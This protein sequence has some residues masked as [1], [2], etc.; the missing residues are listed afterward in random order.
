MLSKMSAMLESVGGLPARF[1]EPL[2]EKEVLLPERWS[3]CEVKNTRGWAMPSAELQDC[4]RDSCRA[5]VRR[6]KKG[7]SGA[8]A[9]V[10][11]VSTVSTA[12]TKVLALRLS[13]PRDGVLVGDGEEEAVTELEAEGEEVEDARR[14]GED[15]ELPEGD[16]LVHTVGV[17]EKID[18][19][20][21]MGQGLDE[22]L[23]VGLCAGLPL[24]VTVTVVEPL[25]LPEPEAQAE[26]VAEGLDEML[27]L[28]LLLCVAEEQ[29][30]ED[31]E[32]E[33]VGEGVE[34]AQW[35]PDTE[36]LLLSEAVPEGVVVTV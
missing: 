28:E 6:G 21:V 36:P 22:G 4:R 11:S 15:K 29:D 30:V 14:E 1:P 9:E 7:R 16:K 10:V 35:L 34:L 19:E 31:S 2:G 5:V 17:L 27:P 18:D 12:G 8:P 25:T 32:A 33:A 13:R 26:M 24:P 20:V 3:T 23:P